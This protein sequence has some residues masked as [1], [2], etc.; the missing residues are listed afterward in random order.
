MLTQD[1]CTSAQVAEGIEPS[2]PETLSYMTIHLTDEPGSN[3]ITHF[4]DCIRF[5]ENAHAQGQFF[6]RCT[7][8]TEPCKFPCPGAA[9][10]QPCMNGKGVPIHTAV[11]IIAAAKPTSRNASKGLSPDSYMPVYVGD[12]FYCWGSWMMF[13][14]AGLCMTYIC[15]V[16]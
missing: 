15:P 12:Q 8:L 3:L 4:P 7:R 11:D 14:L 9:G 10:Y 5:I 1:P 13:F 16:Q 6:E 2:H